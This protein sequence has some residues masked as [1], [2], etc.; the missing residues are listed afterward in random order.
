MIKLKFDIKPISKDNCKITNRQGRQFLPQ[1]Y[2]DWEIVVGLMAKTQYKDKPLECELE[3]WC[4]FVFKDNRRRDVGNYQ[5][6]ILDALKGIC[7][8]DD[9]QITILHLCKIVSDKE[10]I[11]MQINEIKER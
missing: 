11:E 4:W 3:V 5:K 6:S 7:Y 1:K 2:K 9:S 10:C 8:G